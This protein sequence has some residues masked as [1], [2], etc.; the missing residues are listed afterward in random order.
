MKKNKFIPVVFMLILL[1]VSCKKDPGTGGRAIIKGKLK[2]KNYNSSF[3]VLQDEYYA[4][5]ENIYIIYGDESSVGDNIDTAPDGTFEFKYLRK[6]KYKIFAV[7]KDKDNP[8]F[9]GTITISKETEITDKKQVIDLGDIV[10][11]D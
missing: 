11:Y 3:T 7:S 9:T 2:V 5:G 4:P 1:V 8:T 6:G 10:V